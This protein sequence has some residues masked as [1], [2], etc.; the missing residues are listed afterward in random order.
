[1]S[2]KIDSLR[3]ETDAKLTGLRS[4]LT[5]RIDRVSDD[6]KQFYMILG[7]HKG[8]IESLEKC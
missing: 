4:D 7:E 5:A 2:D 8:K 1:M 6:Q 3:I